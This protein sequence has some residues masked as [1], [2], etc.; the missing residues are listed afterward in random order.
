MKR[1]LL[2]A[3]VLAAAPLFAGAANADSAPD[4][5]H[6]LIGSRDDDVQWNWHSKL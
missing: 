6:H 5:Q 4:V 1:P 3:A 2:V